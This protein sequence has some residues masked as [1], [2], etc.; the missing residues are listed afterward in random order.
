MLMRLLIAVIFLAMTAFIAPPVVQSKSTVNAKEVLQKL[1]ATINSYERISYNYYRSINYFSESY[2]H[3]TS[4]ATL[5]DFKNRDTLLGF[6]YLMESEQYKLVYNGAESFSLYKPDKTIAINYKPVLTDF[7]SLSFFLNSIVTLKKALPAIIADEDIAKT[8]TDTTISN[9]ACF[10]VSLILQNKT[11]GGL[12]SIDAT[13][14][15]RTFRYNIV[16][17]KVS[18]LPL[19]I[20][21]RNDAH[22]EDYMLTSFT[23]FNPAPNEPDERS[24]YYSTYLCEYQPAVQHKLMLIQANATAPD[25]Q[26][27]RFDNNDT[28]RLSKFGGKV[29]LLEFWIK[30]CGYC[31]EA[32]PKLN[33]F[34]KKYKAKQLQVIGIN[35]HDTKNDISNFYIRHQP[36]FKTV[37]DYGGKVTKAYGVDA[38]PTIVL[39]DRKGVVLY[40]GDF[41]PDKLDNLL[42]SALR[43]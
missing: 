12:G 14:I 36:Q 35:T 4:G 15:T 25:W 26:L 43:E 33:A 17:D 3:E 32:I 6:R 7:N 2:H 39:I 30:N 21:Q 19:H 37:Y 41:E 38:F 8:V 18:F 11:L 9:K 28:I 13:T 24:W 5:L 20:I 29:L 16:V 23:A 10:L 1:L 40:A 22:P 31:I 27:N 42:K 34:I